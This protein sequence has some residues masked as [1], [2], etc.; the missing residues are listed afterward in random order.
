MI[1]SLKMPP[2]AKRYALLFLEQNNMGQ[3]GHFDGSSEQQF[4]GLLG[5][6]CFK[7]LVTG[8]WPSIESGFDGGFDLEI[9]GRQVDVKTMGRTVKVESGFVHN[10]VLAQSHLAADMLVFQSYIK[11]TN[12]LEVCGWIDKEDAL[13]FGTIHPKGSVR[14]RRDGSTFTTASDLLEVEQGFLKP[15]SG[16]LKVVLDDAQLTGPLFPKPIYESQEL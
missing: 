3:R 12:I 16:Q 14:T 7:R 10:Y 6:I 5:E 1:L 9:E 4:T 8:N 13:A 2:L 15:F 11:K